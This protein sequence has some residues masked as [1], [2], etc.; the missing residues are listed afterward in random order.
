MPSTHSAR[1][2]ASAVA[3]AGGQRGHR[4]EPHLGQP[5]GLV[6]RARARRRTASG[7]RPA[8]TA[9]RAM[10]CGEVPVDRAALVREQLAEPLER[11]AMSGG[12][13]P[14]NSAANGLRDRVGAA[15]PGR[16]SPSSSSPSAAEAEG[17]VAHGAPRAG[18]GPSGKDI[19]RMGQALPRT[20]TRPRTA[21]TTVVAAGAA[22]RA[23]ASGA[24]F[25]LGAARQVPRRRAR[26]SRRRGRSAVGRALAR[27]ARRRARSRRG[28]RVDDR[29]GDARRRAWRRGGRARPG[30]G[31][32][33]RGLD[34]VVHA[35][36]P[37]VPATRPA[38]TRRGPRLAGRGSSRAPARC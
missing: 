27:P 35:V 34:A 9:C 1:L 36:V 29:R 10:S 5:N 8:A 12:R 33:V 31:R 22:L 7:R 2:H 11:R 6:D 26:R 28:R 4:V 25:A 20:A 23:A 13:A 17:K 16:A 30:A 3:A 15:P 18:W 37:D 32:R 14:P 19:A 38:D 21:E 24:R